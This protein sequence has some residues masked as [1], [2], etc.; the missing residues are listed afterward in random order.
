MSRSCI[1]RRRLHKGVGAGLSLLGLHSL[2]APADQSCQIRLSPEGYLREDAD[3]VLA[4][5]VMCSG[6][7]EWKVAQSDLTRDQLECCLQVRRLGRNAKWEDA[8]EEP[9][10]GI[11]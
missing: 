10:A 7:K 3:T 5:I 11:C 6:S 1:N 9:E 4:A 8:I 2:A